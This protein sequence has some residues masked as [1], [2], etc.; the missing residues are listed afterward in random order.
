[1]SVILGI[2]ALA[3]V[4]FT[5]KYIPDD[6]LSYY[7]VFLVAII[8]WSIYINGM[9]LLNLG[10]LVGDYCGAKK[11][12]TDE[13]YSLLQIY[14]YFLLQENKI[15]EITRTT[16]RFLI[17]RIRQEVETLPLDNNSGT[18]NFY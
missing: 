1:M 5:T 11:M 13:V 2:I 3:L 10:T 15:K 17:E 14:N 4:C 8:F 9:S 18:M 16:Q 7:F 6:I 12:K